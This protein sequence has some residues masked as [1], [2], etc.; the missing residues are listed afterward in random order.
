MRRP[1]LGSRTD[2]AHAGRQFPLERQMHNLRAFCEEL[3]RDYETFNAQ[4]TT[5][6]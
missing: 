6:R 2:A 3:V 1:R 4:I 5:T